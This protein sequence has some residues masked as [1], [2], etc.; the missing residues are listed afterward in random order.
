MFFFR[1]ITVPKIFC[2]RD[3]LVFV[4]T[5]LCLA[6]TALACFKLICRGQ[7]MGKKVGKSL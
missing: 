3:L 7:Q 6:L 5:C 2:R 4:S 1:R